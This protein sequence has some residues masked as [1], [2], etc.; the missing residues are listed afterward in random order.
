[1]QQKVRRFRRNPTE[2]MLNTIL[3]EIDQEFKNLDKTQFDFNDI[4]DELEEE[5]KKITDLYEQKLLVNRQF[6]LQRTEFVQKLF[7]K[8]YVQQLLFRRKTSIDELV[9]SVV[10][11]HH[12]NVYPLYYMFFSN[13]SF[14]IL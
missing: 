7:S 3:L 1:M 14:Y 10:L 9:S 5:R 12:D 8:T 11:L 6:M 13:I 4:L 2:K